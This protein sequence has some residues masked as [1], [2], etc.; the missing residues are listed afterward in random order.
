MRL[1]LC[2][3][4]GN[5]LEL[6]ITLQWYVNCGRRNVMLMLL[7][8]GSLRLFLRIMKRLGE[9]VLCFYYGLEA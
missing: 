2:S 8:V 9:L 1:G 5:I 6:M 3:R 4:S 7:E